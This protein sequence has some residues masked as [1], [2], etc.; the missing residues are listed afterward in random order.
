MQRTAG[1]EAGMNALQR[2]PPYFDYLIEGF[3]KGSTS[4]HV[5]LGYW[6]DGRHELPVQGHDDP[7]FARAQ[8]RL[9]DRM[10]ELASL[11]D[12]MAVLDAG[13]GF[14]GTLEQINTTY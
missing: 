14:G 1:D 9:D 5:H 11:T 3:R 6:P 10:V 7:A 8:R 2:V 12:G 4:R 13:C